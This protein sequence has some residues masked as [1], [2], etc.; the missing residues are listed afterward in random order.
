M[1][2]V[3]TMEVDALGELTSICHEDNLTYRFEQTDPTAPMVMVLS[4][5]ASTE[6]GE[7]RL[8]ENAKVKVVIEYE[9]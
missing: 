1:G 7:P 6:D 5:C 9:D 8:F 3:K 2:D 4:L